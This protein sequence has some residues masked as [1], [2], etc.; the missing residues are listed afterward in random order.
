MFYSYP[1]HPFSVGVTLS[2]LAA[3]TMDEHGKET[4]DTSGAL[5][6][7]Q[8]V[9]ALLINIDTTMPA[10]KLLLVFSY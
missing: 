1:E 4:F 10:N 6:K 9:R 2:K 7:L 5:D 8:K 3:V